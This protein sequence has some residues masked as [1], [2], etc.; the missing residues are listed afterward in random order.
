MV[1]RPC[2]ARLIPLV[3]TSLDTSSNPD[4]PDRSASVARKFSSTYNIALIA[5]KSSSFEA[6]VKEIEDKGGKAFGFCA[7]VSDQESCAKAIKDIKHRMGS[8]KLAAAV[9]NVGGTFSK[10]PFLELEL[11]GFEAGWKTGG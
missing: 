10:K 3:H 1:A 7:D 9:Y 2:T 4:N 5:R 6:L 11:D 8:A